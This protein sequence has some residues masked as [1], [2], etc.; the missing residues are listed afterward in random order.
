L[1]PARGRLFVEAEYQHGA[2]VA[3]LG[4]DLANEL[5]P[6]V[7]PIGQ[8]LVIGEWPFHV[9]GVLAWV[10]DE[11][12]GVP[13]PSDRGLYV[14][15]RAAAAAF[16]GNESASIARFRLRSVEAAPAAIA[17][18]RAVLDPRRRARGE[19]SGEFQIVNTLERVEQLSLVLTVI[20]L[21]V[22]LVGSI[23]LFV[24]AVGI[25]NVLLVSVRE[26]RMEIGVRR[27]VGATRRAIFAGFL[28]EA[29][30]MTLAGG[31]LGILAAWGLTKIAIFIPQVP[32]DAR[33][34]ISLFTAATAVTLLTLVGLL[35]GVW[36]ARRAAS[37]FPAE[38]LRAE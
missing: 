34:H 13:A 38:A 19:T 10:G 2:R 32:V 4:A 22:G 6:S 12:A 24:G 21:V 15:F 18:T 7:P 16:R 30:A 33:P 28:L 9:V 37:V 29:L 27:A 17:D 31:L 11:A 35:A 1:Q 14:P 23:G 3:V 36:P 26:R 8:A 20:K 25:A 5:F